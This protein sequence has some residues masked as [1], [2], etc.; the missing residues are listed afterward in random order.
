[1]RDD[2]PSIEEA[3]GDLKDPHSRAP[4]HDLTEMP[5]VPDEIARRIVAAGANDVLAVKENQPTLL[6]HLRQSLDG[7]ARDPQASGATTT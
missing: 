6:A 1:M 7:F 4:A 3:F 5:M 2:V